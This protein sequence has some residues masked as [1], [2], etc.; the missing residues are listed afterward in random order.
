MKKQKL[1]ALATMTMIS[2]A[3]SSFMACNDSASPVAPSRVPAAMTTGT[4]MTSQATTSEAIA[5]MERTIQDEYHAE[6]I[7]LRVLEDFGEV[8][9]FTN[10]VRAEQRH[11]EAIAGLFL[12][13]GLDVPASRWNL[14]NVPRFDS[15]SAACSAAVQAER[16]NIAMYDSFLVMA[17]PADVQNVFTN[18]RRASLEKHMPAFELCAGN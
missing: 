11:S 8:R 15:L 9:P 3:L 12:N 17:L 2:V 7:Y 16:E 6:N 14:G 5:A 1:Q 13:R 18:N 10:V 4:T